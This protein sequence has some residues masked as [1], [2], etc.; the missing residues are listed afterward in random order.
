MDDF[1][2][3]EKK[4]FAEVMVALGRRSM[5]IIPPG[6][7][8]HTTQAPAPVRRVVAA[9]DEVPPPPNMNDYIRASANG[10]K[11]AGPVPGPSNDTMN[12]AVRR[13]AEGARR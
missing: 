10:T 6:T 9:A 5:R 8:R 11:L 4:E 13:R 1:T 7:A 3:E 2:L 12:A